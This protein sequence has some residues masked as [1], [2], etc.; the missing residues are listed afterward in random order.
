MQ[1][2]VSNNGTHTIMDLGPDSE[3]LSVK[4]LDENFTTSSL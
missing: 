2:T 1:F 3:I 4:D